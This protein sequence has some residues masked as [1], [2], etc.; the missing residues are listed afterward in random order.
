MFL[1]CKKKKRKQKTL[2][3]CA[4]IYEHC[5]LNESIR[6]FSAYAQTQPQ[7]HAGAGLH[8]KIPQLIKI[9]IDRIDFNESDFGD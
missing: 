5:D 4:E 7:T 9:M 6:R 8:G 3:I 2:E 1:L